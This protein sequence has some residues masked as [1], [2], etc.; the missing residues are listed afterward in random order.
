MFTE[1]EYIKMLMHVYV[2]WISEAEGWYYL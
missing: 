2:P 1:F